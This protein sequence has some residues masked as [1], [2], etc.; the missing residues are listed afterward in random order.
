[1]TRAHSWVLSWLA[2]AGL[3]LWLSGCATAPPRSTET[4]TAPVSLSNLCREQKVDLNVDAVTQVVTLSKNNLSAKVLVGSD[5][6]LIGNE[7]IMLSAP[8][9][10]VKG[11][12]Y[13]PSD[14]RRKV[15][16]RFGPQDTFAVKKF[17]QIV[18]DPGHGGKDP[19][20]HGRSGL[21]EKEVVLDIA[22]RLKKDLEASGIKVIMTRD[23]DEFISLKE[24]TEIATR[25]DADLFVSVHANSSRSRSAEGFEVFYLRELNSREKKDDDLRDNQR[26]KFRNFSMERGSP[27]LDSIV[28]DMM[29]GYK[30]AESRHLA[31]HVMLRTP[32]SL[33]AEPR[34]SKSCAFFVLRNTLI[35]AILVEVGF[36][37]NNKEEKKLKTSVYREKI[38]DSLAKHILSYADQD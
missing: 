21:K 12:V 32:H 25:S 16:D 36:V 27:V 22:K 8:I 7:K 4:S 6:V 30:Q 10:R 37:S 29:Y 11:A 15:I 33:D 31:E 38:A 18:I 1:M 17:R 34:G 20:A 24:R 19:G 14:F 28:T 3:T 9:R 26:L 5:V 23:S 2:L 13:V 35:P